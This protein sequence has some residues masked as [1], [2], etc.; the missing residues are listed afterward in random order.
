MLWYYPSLIGYIVGYTVTI[1]VTAVL[2]G[3]VRWCIRW[4]GCVTCQGS[5]VVMYG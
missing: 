5:I 1:G 2:F 4:A 3:T